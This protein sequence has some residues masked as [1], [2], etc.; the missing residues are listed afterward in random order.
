MHGAAFFDGL[1]TDGT[2]MLPVPLALGVAGRIRGDDAVVLSY[3]RLAADEVTTCHGVPTAVPL[4]CLLDHV[5]LQTDPREAVVAVDM[6]AAARVVGPAA[7][8]TYA[9]G[10]SG[11]ERT[12]L[13]WA[14]HFASD[15]A[16][17]PNETRLRLVAELD[18]GFPRLLVN[19]V[20]HDR[21][22]HRLGEVDLL[23][24]DAGL[25][26][27]YDGADHREAGQHSHDVTKEAGLRGVGLEVTRVTGA[28]LRRPARL[29]DRL[30]AA[31]GRALFEPPAWRAW[32][33]TP[34]RGAD[35]ST[36]RR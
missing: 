4:R 19:P 11:R 17:S 23:D 36:V 12:L 5:R 26:I 2:T 33:A 35:L 13:L 7:A 34:R 27:E 32:V 9:E 8:A 3:H 31:R 1:A 29:V 20:V 18:A 25:V 15:G 24:V 10:L 30:L 16:R 22:G 14:A 21:S 6:L 28:D